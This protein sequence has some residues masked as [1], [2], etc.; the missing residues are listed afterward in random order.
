MITS[1]RVLVA[2]VY[3]HPASFGGATILAENLIECL[4]Q[5]AKVAVFTTWQSDSAQS[6][7]LVRYEALGVPVFAVRVPRSGPRS[8][9]HKNPEVGRVFAEVLD[10]FAPDVV[11]L[12]SIQGLSASIAEAC[13]LAGVPYVVTLHD[14]WWICERQFMINNDGRDC[15]QTR[16]DFGICANCIPDIQF[17]LDR[18][19]YLKATLEYAALL[20]TPSEYQRQL[21]LANGFSEDQ[22]KVNRNGVALPGKPVIPNYGDVVRFGFVGGVGPTKGFDLICKAFSRLRHRNYELVLVDNTLNLGFNAMRWEGQMPH[23]RV[24]IIP[25]YKREDID[26]FF[27]K[28]DVLLFPSRWRESFGLIVREALIRD[29]WVVSA[30]TGAAAEDIVDGVNGTLVLLD[31]GPAPLAQA[32]EG[33]LENPDRLRDHSN[34]YKTRI[35]TLEDQAI[36]LFAHLTSAVGS[37]KVRDTPSTSRG[38]EAS[39]GE[40]VSSDTIEFEFKGKPVFMNSVGGTDLVV[41]LMVENNFERPLP[42]V[43]YKTVENYRGLVLDVGA[44]SGVYSILACLAHSDT[45]V[46]AFEPFPRAAQ[47]LRDNVALN[48]LGERVH[49]NDDA[50][51]DKTCTAPLYIPDQNHGLLDTSCSLQAEFQPAKRSIEASVKRLDDIKLPDAPTIMKIDVEGH[52]AECLEGARGTIAKHRPIIFVEILPRAD[53]QKL[54]SFCRETNYVDVRLRP[55]TCVVAHKVRFDDSAWNHAFVPRS[56][57]KEWLGL[58]NSPFF[59]AVEDA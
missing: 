46:E 57:M 12:H 59:P 21:Y 9:E 29:K 26:G 31:E 18:S 37:R 56:T 54:D 44:S 58:V 3:F 11:H 14:L 22:V 30:D 28:I 39:C 50:L 7:D 24:T 25:A 13:R 55:S 8:L 47:V 10:V 27:D 32:I 23:G 45:R 42:D 48:G 6:Y 16:I 49:V 52:E 5:K 35:T 4:V 41:R 2:N 38:K 15:G 36:E 40:S 1:L 19:Q 43:F 53:M 20:L 33:L 17:T 51:S 34:I